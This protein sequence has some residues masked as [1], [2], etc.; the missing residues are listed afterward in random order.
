MATPDMTYFALRDFSSIRINC[1]HQGC[2]AGIELRLKNV[3]EVF[4][5]TGAC[6][7]VCGKPFTNPKAANG[8]DVISQLAGIIIALNEL[9]PQVGIDLPMA[10]PTN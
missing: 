2:T 10:L 4:K 8:A 3:E 6:C 7:P 1:H 5:K 9:S